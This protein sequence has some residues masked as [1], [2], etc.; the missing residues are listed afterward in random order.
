M[1][2]LDRLPL[3][4]MKADNSVVMSALPSRVRAQALVQ[5]GKVYAIYLM[6]KTAG[7]IPRR[8]G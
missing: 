1:K 4:D 6:R 8:C 3:L 2:F 5:E 7:A